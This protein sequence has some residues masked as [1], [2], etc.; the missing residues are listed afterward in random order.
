M[1]STFFVSFDVILQI[2]LFEARAPAN[3]HQAQA[4]FRNDAIQ[5]PHAHTQANRRHLEAQQVEI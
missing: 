4:A 2:S 5:R 1:A 3:T